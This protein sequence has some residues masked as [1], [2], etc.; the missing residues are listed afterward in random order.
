MKTSFRPTPLLSRLILALALSAISFLSASQAR[1]A[2][3]PAAN[4]NTALVISVRG[5]ATHTDVAGTE[6][7]LKRGMALP[8][9]ATITTGPT[10]FVVLRIADRQNVLRV[11]S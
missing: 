8:Q 9:G 11:R 10:G 7:R 5:S 4:A 1:A 2:A 6:S 3:K